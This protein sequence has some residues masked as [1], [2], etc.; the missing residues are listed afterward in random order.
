M[1][2]TAVRGRRGVHH[3]GWHH[4]YQADVVLC[5]AVLGIVASRH[6]PGSEHTLRRGGAMTHKKT[7]K[8]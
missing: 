3:A 8:T 2:R 7:C 1:R 4:Y 6:G 5:V